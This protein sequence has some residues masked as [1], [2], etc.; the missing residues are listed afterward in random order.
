MSTRASYGLCLRLARHSDSEWH[1]QWLTLNLGPLRNDGLSGWRWLP[2]EFGV[3][4]W[5]TDNVRGYGPCGW[6]AEARLD[7][8]R[9]RFEVTTS[10]KPD[11]R[12]ELWRI[13]CNSTW[14]FIH[15]GPLLIGVTRP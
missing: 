3:N 4:R 8:N 2:V 15:A 7:T 13:T 1:Y 6:W 9:R 10:T 11:R 5:F 14:R 12:S